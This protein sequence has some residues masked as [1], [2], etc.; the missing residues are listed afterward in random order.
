MTNSERTALSKGRN[1]LLLVWLIGAIV[2]VMTLAAVTL[3]TSRFTGSENQ[4]WGWV[5]PLIFPNATMMLGVVGAAALLPADPDEKTVSTFFLKTSVGLS[6]A[7]LFLVTMTIFMQAMPFASNTKPIDFFSKTNLFLVPV[8]GLATAA[9]GVLF[10]STKTIPNQND[11]HV[12][13]A[14]TNGSK[15]NDD[16]EQS[17]AL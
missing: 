9:I 14:V 16:G 3:I 6:I 5:S 10:S 17:T 13:K 7:F 8:Q 2:P 11:I 12:N 1:Q 15:G 4:I